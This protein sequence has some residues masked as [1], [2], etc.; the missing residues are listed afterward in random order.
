M[1]YEWKGIRDWQEHKRKCQI[2]QAEHC[3][4]KPSKAYE[5]RDEN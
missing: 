2:A 4:V 1:S 5:K 3:S